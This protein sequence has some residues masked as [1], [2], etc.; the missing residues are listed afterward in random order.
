MLEGLASPTASRPV[1]PFAQVMLA[2]QAVYE[3]T[4]ILPSVLEQKFL[5][6]MRQAPDEKSKSE[7]VES[8][9]RLTARTGSVESGYNQGILSDQIRAILS[10]VGHHPGSIVFTRT[11]ARYSE[12]IQAEHAMLGPMENQQD[13]VRQYRP[14]FADVMQV[15]GHDFQYDNLRVH[16]GQ[17]FLM[18]YVDEKEYRRRMEKDESAWLPKNRFYTT[19]D[20][21]KTM[22][23]QN[24]LSGEKLERARHAL[25]GK[26]EALITLG[27]IEDNGLLP[28]VPPSLRHGRSQ[29]RASHYT[30][31]EAIGQGKMLMEHYLYSGI[32][33]SDEESVRRM[34]HEL[35]YVTEPSSQA[36]ARIRG[37]HGIL[38]A[39][40]FY[41]RAL[42]IEELDRLGG[43]FNERSPLLERLLND[44]SLS[45]ICHRHQKEFRQN[46]QPYVTA[47]Q[48]PSGHAAGV[49]YEKVFSEALI[50][51]ILDFSQFLALCRNSNAL[52]A[53]G[54]ASDPQEYHTPD[55][56]IIVSVPGGRAEEATLYIRQKGFSGRS[57]MQAIAYQGKQ[58]PE[59]CEHH[60]ELYWRIPAAKLLE[61][62]RNSIYSG[63]QDNRYHKIVEAM[64]Y[65]ALQL[66]HGNAPE[67]RNNALA[68]G[69]DP[70]LLLEAEKDFSN[71]HYRKWH[72]TL[73]EKEP[74][75]EGQPTEFPSPLFKSLMASLHIDRRIMK[76]DG[77]ELATMEAALEAAKQNPQ[78]RIW[79][80][81]QDRQLRMNP[82]TKQP[83][84][85]ALLL[86]HHA[87]VFDSHST[88]QR[89]IGDAMTHLLA[90]KP[91][92]QMIA[93]GPVAKRWAEANNIAYRQ[94][95]VAVEPSLFTQ[96][97]P[98][99]SGA[100]AH[101]G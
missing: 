35:G 96:E 11:G 41:E 74:G 88:M 7:I 18:G 2:D 30:L 32:L 14:N 97:V 58:G 12:K 38:K 13:A 33:P 57:G 47:E 53:S 1:P 28:P 72:V 36:Q 44:E 79:I 26:G 34:A 39:Q 66:E 43:L 64:L 31:E 87:E 98:A 4:G 29:E 78:A 9:V 65:P 67:V 8:Y 22:E 81:S 90:G 84:L 10:Y 100:L 77:G 54:A 86:R 46:C 15:L 82:E 59:P 25:T 63:K 89:E 3:L 17:M 16:A 48:A 24:M 71:R 23:K 93:V 40:G 85:G 20:F 73:H 37:T 56:G 55:Y 5:P 60:H 76:M 94:Q 91:Q 92:M 61:Q 27:Q 80:C 50:S 21:L 6:A 62:C 83:E 75:T 95:G 52:S 19:G 69:M 99:A 49:P 51:G 101:R 45:A 68:V 42:T 70:L